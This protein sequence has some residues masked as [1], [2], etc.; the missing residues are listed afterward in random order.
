MAWFILSQFFSTLLTLFRLGGTSEADKDLEIR[1]CC[2]FF[3]QILD[4][5]SETKRPLLAYATKPN[6]L[7]INRFCW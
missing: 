4:R 1:L 7:A 5:Q 2:K 3:W 6:S